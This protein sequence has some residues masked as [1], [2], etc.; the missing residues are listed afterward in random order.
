MCVLR[1]EWIIGGISVL[2]AALFRSVPALATPDSQLDATEVQTPCGRTSQ[3]PGIGIEGKEGCTGNFSISFPVGGINIWYNSQ[4][5]SYNHTSPI[6]SAG[7]RG[8]GYGMRVVS[9][10]WGGSTSLS[11]VLEDGSVRNFTQKQGSSTIWESADLFRGDLTRINKIGSGSTTYYELAYLPGKATARYTAP[12]TGLT[13]S[14]GRPI[15]YKDE[16]GSSLIFTYAS[17]GLITTIRDP[18]TSNSITLTATSARVT[19][20]KDDRG[21]SYILSYTPDNYLSTIR[22]PDGSTYQLRYDSE[23]RGY[24]TSVTNPLGEDLLITYFKHGRVKA[25]GTA[26]DIMTYSYA[27]DRITTQR[28]NSVGEALQ[29]ASTHFTDG[30]ATEFR[31]GNGA[32]SGIL[33]GLRITTVTRDPIRRVTSSTDQFGRMTKFYYNTDLSCLNNAGSPGVSLFPTCIEGLDSKTTIRRGTDRLP[34]A[35]TTALQNG[36]QIATNFTWN[37][38][39]LST[40]S[41]VDVVGRNTYSEQTT[42]AGPNPAQIST[43]STTYFDQYD[44]TMR[45]RL[46]RVTDPSGSETI[47]NYQPNGAIK[48]VS[49]DG[50]V[51]T[52]DRAQ[53]TDGA[54]TVT[55]MGGGLASITNSNFAGSS[56][57]QRIGAADSQASPDSMYMALEQLVQLAPGSASQTTTQITSGQGGRLA[58]QATRRIAIDATGNTSMTSEETIHSAR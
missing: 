47:L 31:G 6:P 9:E 18:V 44:T 57:S 24:L 58:S 15:E 8:F 37:D 19:T 27:A 4:Y 52:V 40:V 30:F 55:V 42:Y 54:S 28:L 56:I 2:A 39:K 49:I 3:M 7:D 5:T 51:T 21:R 1:K 12:I 41:I 10:L 46:K 50:T 33:P 29:F 35:V 43:R 45:G 25:V 16:A 26:T 20:I 11:L 38:A 34:V 23:G 53:D 22:Q 32:P 36:Q 17:S 13:P 48:D 14:P